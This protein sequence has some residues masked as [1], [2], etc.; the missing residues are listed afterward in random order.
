MKHGNL[1]ASYLAGA[2]KGWSFF[3]PAPKVLLFLVMPRAF[4]LPPSWQ[5]IKAN[6]ALVAEAIKLNN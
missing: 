4:S 1:K 2:A 6:H 3:F 5:L